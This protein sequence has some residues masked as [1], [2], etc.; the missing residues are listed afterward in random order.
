MSWIGKIIGIFIGFRFGGF[1]GA[2][3]G[4]IIG[5]LADTYREERSFQK[6]QGTH[7]LPFLTSTFSLLA[8]LAR[9]DGA[10]SEHEIAAIERFMRDHLN[11]DEDSRAV[12][13]D[14]FRK[15]KE[16]AYSFEDYAT[17]FSEMFRDQRQVLVGMVHVLFTVALSDGP[18]HENEARMISNAARIFGL[19]DAEYYQIRLMYSVHEDQATSDLDNAYAILGCARNDTDEA[20]RAQYRKLAQDYHPD[21]IAAKGLPEE[22][23]TFA[24]RKFQEIQHAYEQVTESRK[25]GHR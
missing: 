10:V 16:S 1:W 19:T 2:V 4:G 5:H 24:T 6:L 13:I 17:Q 22:F 7:R 11:L 9:A 18:I 23:V 3:L 21:K 14:I 20:I 15:A 25:R 8:K 12:A